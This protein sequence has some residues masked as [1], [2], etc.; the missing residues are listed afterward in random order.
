MTLVVQYQS[1]I[2]SKAS[3]HAT[4]RTLTLQIRGFELDPKELRRFLLTFRRFFFGF[5]IFFLIFSNL[6]MHGF[7]DTKFF[8]G[9][10]TRTL[11]GLAVLAVLA[12]F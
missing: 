10:K 12:D 1:W 7:H 8:S 6:M 9:T 2:Y 5:L 3:R 11:P 4:L